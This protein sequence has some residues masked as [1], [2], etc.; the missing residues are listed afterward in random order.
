V[1]AIRQALFGDITVR[2]VLR[3]AGDSV[4]RELLALLDQIDH[5]AYGAGR[6]L[7]S[8]LV[9][10]SPHPTRLNQRHAYVVAPI[11]ALRIRVDKVRS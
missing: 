3:C 10:L 1:N 8:I 7:F 4:R 9:R 2:S 5:L 11:P 6:G